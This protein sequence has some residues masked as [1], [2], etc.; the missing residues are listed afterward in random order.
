MKKIILMAII[1]L[2]VSLP[3][4]TQS[5][6]D[7]YRKSI[8]EIKKID[9]P[10]LREADVFWSKRY[11]RLIDLREKM[12]QSLYYPTVTTLDGRK[13]F[14]NVLLDGIKEGKITA[15]SVNNSEVPT[16]YEEIQISM[17]A[18]TSIQEIQIDA[19]GNTK[20]DTITQEAKPEEVKQLL[21]YEE[22]FF[23]KKHSKLDVRIIGIM[24][25]WMGVDQELQRTLKKPLFWVKFDEIRDLLATKEVFKSN[26]DAQRLSF[27]DLF[28]QR[29]FSSY[30]YGTS[31][32]FND[33]T[34]AEYSIGKTALFEAEKLKEELFN[35]EQDLWEY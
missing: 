29:K 33:R 27:D 4:K 11:Y 22:W 20:I 2:T 10:Y 25:Y 23:D 3:G 21:L 24:P 17:G 9:Y 35:F 12:N 15:Y 28:M 1:A 32:V 16:T 7:I 31:N 8:P 30:I 5:F 6:G 26:N 13:S 19:A 14:I 34:I 18:T